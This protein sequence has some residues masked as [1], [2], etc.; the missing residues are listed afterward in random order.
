MPSSTT[1]VTWSQCC[2]PHTRA[3]THTKETLTHTACLWS[4][5]LHLGA[6]AGSCPFCQGLGGAQGSHS[7]AAAQPCYLGKFGGASFKSPRIHQ[8]NIVVIRACCP[9]IL[10]R[11]HIAPLCG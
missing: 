3:N 1:K 6:W 7:R 2:S 10:E 4:A 8:R 11:H 5:T 9:C